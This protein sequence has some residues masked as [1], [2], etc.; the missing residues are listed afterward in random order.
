M[1]IHRFV[2]KG[3]LYILPEETE[4]KKNPRNGLKLSLKNKTKARI[5]APKGSLFTL[6][7]LF[8]RLMK[9]KEENERNKRKW[10][11]DEVFIG[12]QSL[13]SKLS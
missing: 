8:Q 7:F 2:E 4:V 11:K 1:Q 6:H 3:V 13:L 12:K 9:E 10:S 5:S